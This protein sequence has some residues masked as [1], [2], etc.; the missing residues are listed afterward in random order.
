MASRELCDFSP[1]EGK[2]T[3]SLF[4]RSDKV[5]HLP[6]ILSINSKVGAVNGEYLGT[7]VTLA[8]SNNRRIRQI[9]GGVTGHQDAQPWPVG[10]KLEIQPHCVALEQLKQRVDIRTIGAQEVGCF[11]HDRLSSQNR[12]THLSH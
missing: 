11:G 4:R 7:W 5:D 1:A 12:G 8:K 9:H 10:R 6:V 2:E 3:P